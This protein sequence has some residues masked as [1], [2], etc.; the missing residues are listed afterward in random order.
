MHF[1]HFLHYYEAIKKIKEKKQFLLANEEMLVE[2]LKNDTE[3]EVET[4][5]TEEAGSPTG[6]NDPEC[7]AARMSMGLFPD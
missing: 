5:Q 2:F 4:L 6:G 7:P 3:N 1:F